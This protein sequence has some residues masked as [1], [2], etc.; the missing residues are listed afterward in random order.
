MA[1]VAE[2]RGKTA[3][4]LKDMLEQL[5]KESFN[6]RFQR[7]SGE[8]SDT[9]RVRQVRRDIARVRMVMHELRRTAAQ[10]GA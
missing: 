7:A 8:L 6:L 3:D 5:K 9:S 10:A 1:K 2:I 4:Q